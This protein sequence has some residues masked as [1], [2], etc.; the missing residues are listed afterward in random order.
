MSG[1]IKPNFF[2]I[3]AP[4]CGTTSLHAILAQHPQVF[5]TR[6]KEPRFFSM[7][8]RWE[9]GKKWYLN[10]YFRGAEAYPIRGESTPST[11]FWYE[12]TIPRIKRVLDQ[13]PA[14]F[15]ILL[16]NPIERAYSHYWFNVQTKVV[17]TEPLDFEEALEAE[18]KRAQ[19][20][21]Y[22]REGVLSYFYAEVG[23]YAHQVEAF[24]Q[25]FGEN[26]V[27]VLLFEDLF[28]ERYD[29]SINQIEVFLG[30]SRV[31]LPSVKDNASHRFKNK[32]IQMIVRFIKPV[33]EV[34]NPYLPKN[35][36]KSLREKYIEENKESFKYPAMKDETRQKLADQF[37]QSNRDLQNLIGRDLSHW[38]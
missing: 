32:S 19:I 2:I 35:V 38:V 22:H 25:A 23:K 15:I 12:K 10:K 13:E 28:S 34:L 21:E 17:H 6:L 26:N 5:M 9:K 8:S 31:P 36:L 4:K 29:E 7:D 16:R 11:L 3:G 14:K 37:E 1:P 24:Q 33:R 30:I 20:S 18:S 27:L